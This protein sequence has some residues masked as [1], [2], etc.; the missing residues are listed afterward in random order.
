MTSFLDKVRASSEVSRRSFVKASAAAS[1]VLAAGAM[2]GCANKVEMADTGASAG[3]E[4]T[5]ETDYGRN[6]TLSLIH[7]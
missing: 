4:N 2:A 7:I 5:S 3:N 1:A 6:L